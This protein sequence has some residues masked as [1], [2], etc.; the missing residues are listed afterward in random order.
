MASSSSLSSN[1]S[2]DILQLPSIKQGMTKE[3]EADK[4]LKTC[5]FMEEASRRLKLPQV[6]KATAMVFF[7]RFYAKHSF[8]EHDRFEVAVACELTKI[9]MTGD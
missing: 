3:E 1:V 2:F 5:R 9:L 6:A 8:Q 4:R 7:H